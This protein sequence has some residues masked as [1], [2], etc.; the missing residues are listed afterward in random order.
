MK[1][2]VVYVDSMAPAG[3]IER[4]I[5]NLANS[6][7]KKYSIVL[8]VKD[9]GEVFYTL[10]ENI[11]VKSLNLPLEINMQKSKVSRIFGFM[12]SIVSTHFALKKLLMSENPDFIYTANPLNS[13]EVFLLG[14]RYLNKLIISEH[15]S[16]FGYNDVYNYIKKMVYPKARY[17]SVPTIM[18]T[19]LYKQEGYPAV[20]IP[21][22]TTF[23]NTKMNHLTNKTILNVGRLT[24]DKRQSL[25]I[26][27]W[28]EFI[29]EENVHDW[30]LTIVGRGENEDALK[31]QIMNLGI[32]ENVEIIKPTPK[33]NEIYQKASVFAF[34]SKYEGFGMVLLEAMSFGIPCVSFDCPSGPRD[35]INNGIDGF[36]IPEGEREEWKR[37]LGVLIRDESKRK[38]MGNAAFNKTMAWDNQKILSQWDG[39]FK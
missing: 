10:D 8:V 37:K 26:E 39:I 5:S 38:A 13:L 25:L 6:W 30:K 35:I 34:T 32:T 28:A 31:T 27:L 14:K 20:Y 3:G 33:I 15:G 19:E 29:K 36:L 24:N 23:S 21:H 4:V 17:I 22:I 18:D 7:V 1:K 2:I 9:A 16:K 12:K 11:L